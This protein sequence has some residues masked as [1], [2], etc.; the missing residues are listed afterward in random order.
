[1]RRYSRGKNDVWQGGR[2]SDVFQLTITPHYTITDM[3]P[4]AATQNKRNGSCE[5]VSKDVK[6]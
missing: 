6:L 2:G 4:R 3:S 5:A 1:M